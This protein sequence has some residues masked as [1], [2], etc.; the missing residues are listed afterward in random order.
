[1]ANYAECLNCAKRRPA[2]QDKCPDYLRHKAEDIERV[3]AQNRESEAKNDFRC[4]RH[5]R[6]KDRKGL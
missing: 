3:A 5:Q 1:M 4:V 2:C 6:M